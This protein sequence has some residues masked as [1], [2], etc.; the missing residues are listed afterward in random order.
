M[1][2]SGLPKADTVDAFWHFRFVPILLQKSL[3]VSANSDSVAVL[4]LAA[5]AIDDGSA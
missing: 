1:M 4:G 3:M 5:G 2:S